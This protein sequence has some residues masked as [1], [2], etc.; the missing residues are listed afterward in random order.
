ML[1]KKRAFTFAELM[2]S[3]VIIGV[4]T[5]IMY[6]TISDL[7]PNN[8]KYLFK[9][10]Y[11]TITMIVSDYINTKG[12]DGM[13]VDTAADAPRLC[14]LFCDKLNTTTTNAANN[15]CTGCTTF[16][17]SN[18]M[19]WAF[20][21]NAANKIGYVL[22]DVN[23]SNNGNAGDISGQINMQPDNRPG[24]APGAKVN[25]ATEQIPNNV[26]NINNVFNNST[27]GVFYTSDTTTKDTFLFSIDSN[28]RVSPF[29]GVAATH[30]QSDD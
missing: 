29:G 30:L 15:Q 20:S 24:A 2:I 25:A 26:F 7:A 6:P 5:L 16:A 11:Q 14:Q 27:D 19:R 4:I 18:G 10:T 21:V 1:D 12:R 28:G 9:E 22:V 13:P 8:N 3:L 17:T 23:A